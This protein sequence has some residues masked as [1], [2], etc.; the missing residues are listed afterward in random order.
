MPEKI[1]QRF[2]WAVEQL[3][4]QPG[5]RVLE[6]GCGHGF[7]AA[8]ICER[9]TSGHLTGI[10]RS[11]KMIAVASKRNRACLEAG[12]VDFQVASLE[13]A[14]FGGARFDS[15]FA[16]NVNVFWTEPGKGLDR[17]QSWLAPGGIFSL[18]YMPPSA[19]WVQYY[20]ESLDATLQANGFAPAAIR[21]TEMDK[22]A[23]VAVMAKL[24]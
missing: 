12:K 4:I 8:L 16:F 3:A 19:E 1:H 23:V 13:D 11:E 22:S 9:L 17:I 6:I 14:D 18:F 7:A 5:D 24:A 10:D 20:G 2:H 15:I 21:T